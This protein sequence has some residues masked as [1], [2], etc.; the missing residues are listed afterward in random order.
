MDIRETDPIASA[1]QKLSLIRRYIFEVV[2]IALAIAV[3]FQNKQITYY[4][5]S[6][7]AEMVKVISNNTAV[8]QQ[9]SK[10]IEIRIAQDNALDEIKRKV[11]ENA[12][13]LKKITH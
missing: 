11:D 1:A 2:V 6:D 10:L 12:E 3:I 4:L 7:R 5:A 9:N 8:V 13:I